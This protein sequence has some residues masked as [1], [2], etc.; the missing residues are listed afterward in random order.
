MQYG[1]PGGFCADNGTAEVASADLYHNKIHLMSLEAPFPRPQPIPWNGT[2]CSQ[3][4]KDPSCVPD[5]IWNSVI[6]GQNGTVRG[7]S[8]LCWYAEGVSSGM[9]VASFL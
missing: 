2:G 4:N 5:P 9:W 7:F 6:G 3:F 1:E 8:A